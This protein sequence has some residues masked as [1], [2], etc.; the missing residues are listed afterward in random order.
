MR[1]EKMISGPFLLFFLNLLN[2]QFFILSRVLVELLYY[3]EGKVWIENMFYAD[4]M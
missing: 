2:F 4:D 1:P 3:D